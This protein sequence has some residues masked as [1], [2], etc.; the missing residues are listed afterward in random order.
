MAVELRNLKGTRDFMP[1]EQKVRQEIIRKLQDIF[2]KYGYQPIETPVVCYFDVLAS[3]YAGGAEILKEVYKLSDQ[4]G[5]E[6][7]LRYDLTVPFARLAGM[8]TDI[9]MPF[10]RYEIGKVFRDGP[11]KA[12]RSREFIQCDVDM[13]GVK[14]LMAEAELM[15]LAVEVYK[16]LGLDVIIS[17]NNRMLLSGIIEST[18]IEPE[19]VSKVIL[20]IDKLEKIGSNGVETE[21]LQLGINA[22]KVNALLNY[23][24]MEPDELISVIYSRQTNEQIYQGVKDL[25]E[26]NSY[27]D[28]L[29][30]GKSLRFAPSLARGLEIYT[31]TVWEVFLTDGSIT[32]S[33]GAGGRYDNIIGA[34]ID[35][36]LDYPALGM[37]FGLDVIYEALMLKGAVSIEPPVDL[38]IIPLS[39]E[40]ACLKLAAELR[41]KG[42][43]VDIDMAGRRL[44][45]SLDYANKQEI[46]YV[47]V[48]G[49]NEL[50]SGEL[51]LK[52]MKTGK[53]YRI[54]MEKLG[55]FFNKSFYGT[56][57]S[58]A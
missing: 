28:V 20:C 51:P 55:E 22:E 35:N 37:T 41:N 10:K 13:V 21:L 36:G 4:G 27:I 49:E 31:G 46:P 18:G 9:R 53:E 42:L 54:Y 11:V 8:N 34:F 48:I 16:T 40:K 44:K 14:S 38:Y 19:L 23:M 5:R 29:G 33:V 12:G 30:I 15:M 32:S 26:L 56:N 6:L 58:L 1:R 24:T 25:N 52:E 7:G 47:V 17:Y 2:E 45:N 39:T 3:K 43:K 50:E 57:G